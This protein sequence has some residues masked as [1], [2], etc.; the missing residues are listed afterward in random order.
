MPL[1]LK[2]LPDSRLPLSIVC[3]FSTCSPCEQKTKAVSRDRKT[4]SI[5]F[6]NLVY[7]SFALNLLYILKVLHKMSLPT[8]QLILDIVLL[9]SPFGD[10][11][12][13]YDLFHIFVFLFVSLFRLLF[14]HNDK[15]FKE[16]S[17]VLSPYIFERN[18]NAENNS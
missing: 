3:I 12:F 5:S 4:D 8:S 2:V 14:P 1:P 11:L 16:C 7:S 13:R 17:F 9:K 10:F 15:T 6:A 18:T